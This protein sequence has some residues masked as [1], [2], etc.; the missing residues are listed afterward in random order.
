MTETALIDQ[1]TYV[2][3][4]SVV[5]LKTKEKYGGLSNMRA[6]F[7]LRVNGI[8][9]RT[10]EALYQVCRFPDHPEV[11]RLII[12]QNSPMAAKNVSKPHRAEKCRPD[13]DEVMV[14]VMRWC[15]RVKLAV[16]RI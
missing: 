8:E 1:D 2:R 11:Q 4:K 12:E 13:W 6:G 7:P 3:A 15:L 5:F 16:C 9:I 10:S 14:E